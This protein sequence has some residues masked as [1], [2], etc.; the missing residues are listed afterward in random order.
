MLPATNHK[1]KYEDRE[2]EAEGTPKDAV[3]SNKIGKPGN[4]RNGSRVS[5]PIFFAGRVQDGEMLSRAVRA[6]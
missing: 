3:I 1:K 4:D 6:V 5:P 2:A